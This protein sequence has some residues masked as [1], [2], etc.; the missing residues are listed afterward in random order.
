ML[1]SLC[2]TIN[3]MFLKSAINSFSGSCLRDIRGIF[4]FIAK[5]IMAP[6]VWIGFIFAFLSL[7]IWLFVLSRADLNL[8]FS[9]DSMHY[10]FI[11]ASSRLILKERVGPQRWTGTVLIVL[12]II[13]VSLS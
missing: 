7:C 6:R 13:L 12:G 2:D 11:A 3:Q 4:S 1:T 9:L 8:A 5:I 10:L